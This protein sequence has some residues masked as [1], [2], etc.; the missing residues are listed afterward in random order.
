MRGKE[1]RFG[2]KSLPVKGSSEK[3]S[4]SPRRSFGAESTLGKVARPWTPPFSPPSCHTQPWAG[5]CPGRAWPLLKHC[6]R[7]QTCCSRMLP[8]DDS[9]GQRRERDRGSTVTVHSH[10]QSSSPTLSNTP[11]LPFMPS[12]K[13]CLQSWPPPFFPFLPSQHF[14][15]PVLFSSIMVISSPL[16]P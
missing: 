12:L 16:L 11:F 8:P 6:G 15:C 9:L 3:V 1:A 10:L 2:R 7:S 5:S 14:L 4:A 13:Q